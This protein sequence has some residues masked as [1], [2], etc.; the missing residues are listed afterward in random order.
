MAG[1]VQ[2]RGGGLAV[3]DMSMTGM[4]CDPPRHEQDRW[5]AGVLAAGPSWRLDGSTLVLTSGATE[6]VLADREV[7]EPDLSLE[8]TEWVV[9]T[10]VD[11][12]VAESTPIGSP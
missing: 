9:D 8:G 7:A 12:E 4:G 2:T 11:G 5:L 1:P 6:L 10:L 3:D